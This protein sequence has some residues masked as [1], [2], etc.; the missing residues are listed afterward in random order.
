MQNADMK[1]LKVQIELVG[2]I[3]DGSGEREREVFFNLKKTNIMIFQKRS[4]SQ[5]TQHTFSLG[6]NQIAH[7]S[8]YN[9]LYS[10]AYINI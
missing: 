10:H 6:T 9:S 3:W 5:G 7:T 8:H 1:W 2:C 4:R